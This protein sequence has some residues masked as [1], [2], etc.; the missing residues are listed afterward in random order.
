MIA[1]FRFRKNEDGEPLDLS[2]DD[3]RRRFYNW[4]KTRDTRWLETTQTDVVAMRFI[5]SFEGLDA[6]ITP[7]QQHKVILL[8]K[9][10]IYEVRYNER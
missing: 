10:L 4:A 1:L 2:S 6:T 9:P 5:E 3:L 8:L 7:D